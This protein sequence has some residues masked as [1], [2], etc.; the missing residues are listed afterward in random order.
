MHR[1]IKLLI[2]IVL[3]AQSSVWA[4]TQ[5]YASTL[6]EDVP[7]VRQKP[8]FC[9]EAAAEM[10]LRS[11]KHEI[12]QDDVFDYSNL[13]PVHGRGC[14]TTELKH[15]L[16]KIGFRVGKVWYSVKAENEAEIEKEFRALHEDLN[17]GIPSIVCTH[18]DKSLNTTEHFRLVVGYDKETDQVIY[19]EPAVDD[20]AYLRM[21]RRHFLELWPLKYDR[22]RWT[23]IRFRMEPENIVTAK[24]KMSVLSKAGYAQH[25]MKLKRKIPSKN[26]HIVIKHPF[27]VIGDESLEIVQMRAKR[28]VG[29]A[30]E[31]LKQDFFDKDPDHII[32]I[33]LF[34]DKTSY[35]KH[36]K[37]IFD[38]EPGTPFG[39]YSETHK[40]LIMNIATGGGT[41]VHEIVH[42]FVHANFPDCPAWFNEG[43]GSLY[44]Q[45][46][47]KDGHIHG[48]TNWRLAGLHAAIKS[49]EVPSFRQLTATTQHEFYTQDRGT[50]YSQARYLCYYL[51]QKGLLVRFYHE[52]V[53]NQK[54]DPTG[55]QSLQ[56]ILDQKDMNEFKKKWEVFVL[57]LSFP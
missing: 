4:A 53:K 16:K 22:E 47:D 18:Y 43:L 10:V 48:Y 17:N 56:K 25:I 14:Y 35:L 2:V 45:C 11:L 54:T 55:Y 52:F 13:N 50:N 41:L 34:K 40:A 38:D 19:H 5:E 28:T 3:G 32:D 39:Y 21:S 30:V 33:W 7:H 24:K 29:W 49:D 1:Y 23:L 36:T 51:Q 46:G 44:E 20:G 12:S 9:G 42:P 31:R 15:A 26:F 57:K 8:D 27:V 6:I 37:S